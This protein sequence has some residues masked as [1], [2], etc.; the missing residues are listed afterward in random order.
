MS[1][2][3]KPLALYRKKIQRQGKIINITDLSSQSLN[4]HVHLYRKD[5]VY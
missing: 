4:K 3:K 5:E 2:V 1:L